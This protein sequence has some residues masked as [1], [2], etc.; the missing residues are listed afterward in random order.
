M[1]ARS[2]TIDFGPFMT[3]RDLLYAATAVVANGASMP[4][5]ELGLDLFSLRSQG[6]SAFEL[7]DFAKKNGASSAHFSEPRFLGSLESDHLKRVREH[8]DQ[9]GL[10]VEVGFG[11]IC[12]TSTRF[13]AEKGTAQE[14][15][16]EMFGA[17]RILGS[18]FVRCY[19][20]SA[21][22]RKGEIPFEKHIEN[23]IAVCKSLRDHEGRHGIKIAVENHA[24]DMQ[25]LQLKQLVEEAGKGHVGALLDPGNATWTL[26]DPLHTLEVLAPYALSTGIRDSRVWLDDEGIN[27]MWVPMGNGNIEI[28]KWAKRFGELRPDLPFSLEIINLASPRKFAVRDTKFWEHYRDVPAWVY[29]GFLARAR[30]GQPYEAPDGDPVE[31]ERRDVAADMA[32]ARR[33]LG[34][35]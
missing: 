20:G 33:L 23:T 15:L 2:T 11:S 31:K 30:G 25:A 34:I 10:A 17:A 13:A 21:D 6:W 1:W 3:R 7:L 8:A 14:Q 24:G 4:K 32:Y 9:L 5:Q 19:L 27:V 18:P 16:L 35:G 29:E 26:E 28:D 12:P 22:D